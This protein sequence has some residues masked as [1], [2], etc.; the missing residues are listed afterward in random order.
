MMRMGTW[1]R[2]GETFLIKCGLGGL[3][4]LGILICTSAGFSI[5]PNLS[6]LSI[7]QNATIVGAFQA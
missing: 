3:T 2:V 1:N 6:Y 4:G 5:S 7:W